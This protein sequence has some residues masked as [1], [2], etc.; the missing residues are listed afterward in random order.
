[1]HKIKKLNALAENL[2]RD[3][4][5]WMTVYNLKMVWSTV[6]R[7]LS[8]YI[9]TAWNGPSAIQEHKLFGAHKSLIRAT[10]GLG[11]PDH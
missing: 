3:Y 8:K 9:I 7:K 5:E 6:T 1:M 10:V 4:F 2:I 11:R